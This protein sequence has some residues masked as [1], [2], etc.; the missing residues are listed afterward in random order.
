VEETER[1]YLALVGRRV[2]AARILAGLVQDGL[3]GWGG[4]DVAQLRELD[5]EG[6]SRGGR[7]PADPVGC[8]PGHVTVG[9][10]RRWFSTA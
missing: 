2:R 1:P 8:R 3:A 5:R 6:R 7:G 10:G 4:R 9:A